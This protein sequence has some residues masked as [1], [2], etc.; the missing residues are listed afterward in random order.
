MKCKKEYNICCD[1]CKTE[2]RATVRPN[3]IYGNLQ[4]SNIK[5]TGKW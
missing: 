1:N 3:H 4:V 5:L 2:L